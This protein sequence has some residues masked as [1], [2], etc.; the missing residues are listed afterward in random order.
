MKCVHCGKRATRINI[1]ETRTGSGTVK[2]KDCVCDRCSGVKLSD[3][4][5]VYKIRRQEYGRYSE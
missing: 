5:D 2:T 1:S 3:C 4:A